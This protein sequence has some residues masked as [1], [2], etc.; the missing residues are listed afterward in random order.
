MTSNDDPNSPKSAA[1]QV[2]PIVQ[3]AADQVR[4]AKDRTAREKTKTLPRS[5]R[6]D[7][8]SLF[9]IPGVTE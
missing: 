9:D 8:Q 5:A 4:R 2:N 6:R 3:A 7:Q 1:S